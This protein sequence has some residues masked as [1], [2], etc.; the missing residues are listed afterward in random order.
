LRPLAHLRLLDLTH[1]LAGPY[2]TLLLAD[3]GMET[4]KIE[5]PGHGESTRKLLAKDPKASVDGL[6]AYFLTLNRNKQSITLDLKAEAGLAIFYDLVRLSDVVV[7]NFSVGVTSRL[8]IDHAH[9]SAINP[10]IITASISGFGQTGPY[11]QQVS[12]DMVAQAIGGIMSITGQQGGEPVRPGVPLGDLGGGLMGALGILSALVA[13]NQTGLGQHVDISML[14]AQI[15]LL[16]YIA[17]AALIGQENPQPMGSAHFAYVPYNAYPTQ[18]D[19]IVI[20]VLTDAF[21]PNLLAALTLPELDTQNHL[22]TA[23]RLANRAHIDAVIGNRLRQAPAA[24]WLAQLTAARVPCAPVNSVLQALAD[25]Q[26]Q[27]RQMVVDVPLPNGGSIKAPGNPI[28]LSGDSGGDPTPPPLLGQHTEA[29]LGRLLGK[30]A[31]ALAQLR[32]DGVI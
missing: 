17:T 27:A 1:V 10:R 32:A 19:Y 18:D 3:L 11:Q 26:V 13:R 5:P 14:D 4:I 30:S 23:G 2:A 24:Y 6:G 31:A 28:K 25:P 15:S 29:V 12:F 20:A 22:T 16:S 7:D 8:G 9:L 21:W